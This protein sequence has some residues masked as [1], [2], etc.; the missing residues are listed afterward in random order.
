MH[1]M[2]QGTPFTRGLA[3]IEPENTTVTNAASEVYEIEPIKEQ[4][5]GIDPNRQNDESTV[6]VRRS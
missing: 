6:C 2:L 5:A 1:L 4:L 3:C